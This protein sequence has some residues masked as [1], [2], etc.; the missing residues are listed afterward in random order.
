MIALETSRR[1]VNVEDRY[2]E[3]MSHTYML[4]IVELH[5]HWKPLQVYL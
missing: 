3:N 4:K 1:Q 2:S 5:P